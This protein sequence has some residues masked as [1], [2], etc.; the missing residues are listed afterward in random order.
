MNEPSRAQLR[1]LKNLGYDGPPPLSKGEA[2]AAIDEMLSSK[3]PGAAQR[4]IVDERRQAE[5]DER[6]EEEEY[7]RL[8]AL[9]E[10]ESDQELEADLAA[11]DGR[12][13]A[14]ARAERGG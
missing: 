5:E 3:D 8:D 7:R 2:S 9:D 1:Y 11:I 6:R 12:L 13:A 10:L 4:A 14:P